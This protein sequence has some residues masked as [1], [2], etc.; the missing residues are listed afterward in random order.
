MWVRERERERR[1]RTSLRTHYLEKPLTRL[2]ETSAEP[3]LGQ[4]SK[5]CDCITNP[6]SLIAPVAFVCARWKGGKEQ[7]DDKELRNWNIQK[8]RCLGWCCS[9]GEPEFIEL[10]EEAHQGKP[11]QTFVELMNAAPASEYNLE[12]IDK[13]KS[14][15]M[16]L[17]N[18]ESS[19]LP[20]P[21]L[22]LSRG[23]FE[24]DLW[25]LELLLGCK[26][27]HRECALLH[28][29]QHLCKRRLI[30]IGPRLDLYS[31]CVNPPPPK[32]I[33]WMTQKEERGK[34]NLLGRCEWKNLLLFCPAQCLWWVLQFPWEGEN[35]WSKTVSFASWWWWTEI[36]D[37]VVF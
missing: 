17:S 30:S 27:R 36:S 9:W 29:I 10:P 1:M 25:L 20:R 23:D 26:G 31:A 32:K 5:K 6:P 21:V 28:L 8:R 4:L 3:Q 22:S 11:L 14:E 34:A 12:P 24:E 16:G 2:E 35:L 19:R 7:S 33:R 18:E 15:K 37:V 13:E